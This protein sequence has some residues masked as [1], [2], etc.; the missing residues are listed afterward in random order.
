MRKS[1]VSVAATLTGIVKIMQRSA[2]FIYLFIFTKSVCVDLFILLD[3]YM[4]K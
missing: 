3:K 4:E 2:V 1:E